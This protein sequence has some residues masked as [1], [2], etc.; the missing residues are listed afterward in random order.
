MFSLPEFKEQSRLER[1]EYTT[2]FGGG[3][4]QIKNGK[5]SFKHLS[6]KYGSLMG[7]LDTF[8]NRIHLS[9]NL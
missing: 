9:G 4:G 8:F 6:S 1:K 3:G 2:L 5:L 7:R